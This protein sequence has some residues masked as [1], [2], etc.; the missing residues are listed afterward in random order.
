VALDG[1]FF[2]CL[3]TKDTAPRASDDRRQKAQKIALEKMV[4]QNVPILE[5]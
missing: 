3:A 1:V 2:D 4:E 5:R